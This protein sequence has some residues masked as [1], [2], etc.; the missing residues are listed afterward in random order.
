MS[1]CVLFDLDGTLINSLADIAAAV[2]HMRDALKLP[3]HSEEAVR[4]FV[5]DGIEQ[6]VTRAT[7]GSGADY[8]QALR[9]VKDYYF[10]HLMVHTSLYP[11]VAEGLQKLREAD[12]RLGVVTNK[13]ENAAHDVLKMFHIDH[14]FAGVA[15]GGGAYPLKPS[16]AGCL[17][18]LERLSC[19]AATSYMVGDHFTDLAA[20][21]GAGMT[22]VLAEWGFGDPQGERIDLRFKDFTAM[23]AKIIEQKHKRT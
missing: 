22:T 2:N 4:E 19:D 21:A 13:P 7:A 18:L 16:P 23:T 8:D 9:L 11:G 6:L 12:F 1:S 3:P 10:S 20:G 15:G 14:L 17:G 5:G